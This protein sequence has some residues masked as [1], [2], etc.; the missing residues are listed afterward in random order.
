MVAAYSQL[1]I[2]LLSAQVGV[3]FQARSMDTFDVRITD[4]SEGEL[5]PE[6]AAIYEY[7]TALRD[8]RIAPKWREFDW[9][10]LPSKFIPWYTVVDVSY[11]PLDF[12]YRFTGSHRVRLQRADYTGCRLNMIEPRQLGEKLV[13]DNKVIVDAFAPKLFQTRPIAPENSHE[14][15]QYHF[16]RLPF[17]H[18]GQQVDQILSFGCYEENEIKKIVDP[19]ISLDDMISDIHSD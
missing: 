16:M 1:E 2:H 14:E 19:F 6:M 18:T 11:D 5:G 13:V 15:V 8:D 4:I 9:F 10:A 3:S 7:W 12:T 17:S